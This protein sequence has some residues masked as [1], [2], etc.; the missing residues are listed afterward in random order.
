[1]Y[2]RLSQK[3]NWLL[4]KVGPKWKSKK[5]ALQVINHFL[6]MIGD[7]EFLLGEMETTIVRMFGIGGSNSSR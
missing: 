4:E 3:L 1:M 5:G 2:Y 6:K 7:V